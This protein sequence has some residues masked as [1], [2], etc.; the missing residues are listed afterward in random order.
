M[1][2]ND[3]N[4]VILRA[5]GLERDLDR[6]FRWELTRRRG[7]DAPTGAPVLSRMDLWGF[8]RDYR[9]DLAADGQMRFMIDTDEGV[10][11]AVTI[12]AVDLC[13]YDADHSS[14]YVGIF[15]AEEMRG[16]G[17]G[18]M[19]LQALSAEA[20]R[21]GLDVLRAV[22]APENAASVRLFESAGFVLGS[23]HTSESGSL[24][25]YSCDLSGYS[26]KSE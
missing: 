17:Y 23:E 16:R 7:Y 1:D 19:A 18:R 3:N 21:L 24:L 14:A 12:G 26:V 2:N 22:V 6:I 5:P 4:I 20:H 11:D 10:E 9:H 15:I 8:L 25:T 13:D